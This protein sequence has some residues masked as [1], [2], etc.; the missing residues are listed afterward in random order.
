MIGLDSISSLQHVLITSMR[1]CTEPNFKLEIRIGLGGTSDALTLRTPSYAVAGVDLLRRLIQLQ[2]KFEQPPLTQ[3]NIP[4]RILNN[5]PVL[6][7]FSAWTAAVRVNNLDA[8]IGREHARQMLSY[9]K[10][11]I[12]NYHPNLTQYIRYE[13]DHEDTYEDTLL[14]YIIAHYNES[15]N[16]EQIRQQLITQAISRGSNEDGSIRYTSMHLIIF[17]DIIDKQSSQQLFH[18]LDET[19]NNE[20]TCLY[21]CIITIGGSVEKRFNEVRYAIRQVFINDSELNNEQYHFPL[22]IRMLSHAGQT[23]VYYHDKNEIT[24]HQI[25]NREITD[26][27]ITD[28]KYKDIK[29]DLSILIEDIG[30]HDISS[31]KNIVST[32]IDLCL[33]NNKTAVEQI[34][35]HYQL[36]NGAECVILSCILEELENK[37]HIHFG[38]R[39]T[40]NRRRSSSI[41]TNRET[42]DTIIHKLDDVL[43]QRLIEF[44]LN[45]TF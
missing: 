43:S 28:K 37:N 31:W 29:E 16:D 23:P 17:K 21:D 7:F 22:S 14:K 38:E 35:E 44:I 40:T 41:C 11:Y 25:S 26:L 33:D 27:H 19:Q 3:G 10:K 36:S 30:S 12:D 18:L 8:N 24:V 34:C 45:Q 5:P 2:K 15:Y 13:M 32:L 39:N 4:T 20:P 9:I 6:T 42:T 1:I